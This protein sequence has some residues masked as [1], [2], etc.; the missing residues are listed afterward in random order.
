MGSN[1]GSGAWQRLQ[2]LLRR[3]SVLCHHTKGVISVVTKQQNCR[4]H[5]NQRQTKRSRTLGRAPAGKCSL[6]P[7]SVSSAQVSS[8]ELTQSVLVSHSLAILEHFS[9]RAKYAT[10]DIGTQNSVF[11]NPKR[12][13]FF[14]EKGSQG[15]RHAPTTCLLSA[16]RA[17]SHVR[18]PRFSPRGL[19]P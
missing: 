3:T 1:C 12:W 14:A 6:D 15:A 13:Q 7:F 10:K 11:Q 8:L 2:G 9:P 17:M 16:F 18:L 4:S 19:E 5:T